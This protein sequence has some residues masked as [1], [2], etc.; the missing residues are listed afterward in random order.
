MNNRRAWL[1]AA[2]AVL[3]GT[4]SAAAA[5]TTTTQPAASAVEEVIVTAQKRAENIQDV[6]LSIMAVSQK[7]MEARG[8][9]DAR[10]LEKVVPNLRLDS[11]AQFAGVSIRIRGFGASSNAAID[12]SV[13]PYIDG[14]FIPRPGAILTTF[15]DVESAEVLRG[16][17]GTLFGRNATV[18]ALSLRTAT[19]RDTFGTKAAIELGSY[20]THKAEGMINAPVNDRL[21][22]RV[23]ALANKT[24]GYAKNLLDGKTYGANETIAGRLSA[25]FQA[26]E[27]VTWIGRV[28]Y[29]RTDGDGYALNQVDVSTLTPTQIAN[30]AARTGTPAAALVYPPT[31]DFAS[32]ITNLNLKDRQYGVSSDL[33]IELGGD[34]TVRMINA[35]RNWRNNQSDGDVVFTPLDLISRDSTFDSKSQSHELQFISPKGALL[36]GKLDFV[37]GLYFF[38]EDYKISEGFNLGSQYCSN[39]IAVAAPA[40]LAACNAGPF[41]GAANGLF[42]QNAK[43]YAAYAQATYAITSTLD[44]ILGA[45]ETKDK[46]HGSFVETVANSAAALLR[47]PENT[48]LKFD[49]S[50]PSWRANLSWHVTPDIMTF[51]TYSTGYKSGGL[52]SA[53]GAAPLGQKRLFNSE[54]SKDWELGMKSVLFDRRLLLNVTAYRTDLDD[55]QERSFDGVSFLIRNA[56]S[57]RAKGVEIEGQ[58]RPIEGVSIDF[59]LAY[60]DSVF[61][62]NKSAPGLPAC[63]GSATSCPTL[64]DLT[65]RRPTY[66]PKWQGNIGA[67]YTTPAFADGYTLSVRGDMAYT[68]SMYTTND[69]SEQGVDDSFT[70]YSGRI[71]LT[72]PDKSWTMA[73]FGDN[74]TNEHYFRGAKFVQTL[75]SIFGV[76]IPATGGTLY[77]GYVGAPRTWGIRV[78]K[79]Y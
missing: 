48:N 61:T 11:I 30:F 49:D 20:G 65:G 58:A 33:S 9:V 72:G 28:D 77:R 59:G 69:L 22:I 36:G 62:S 60:L 51:V 25:K 14:V 74:L 54:K 64:Q 39:V 17:Q 21:A 40:R 18:G 29:A 3:T 10:G 38:E 73:L 13:A 50:Q 79:T 19:P 41:I 15:L 42:Q 76:R 24:D 55:F 46:K 67:E 32:A 1:L 68:G 6:P 31:H 27:N 75:D 16:P 70:L 45:R 57:I 43:S 47:G 23:A 52:N 34:Y 78:T 56:G 71:T 5:Q 66:S 37:A 53:G 8:V 7:A 63:N 44:L 35:Y 2:S 12:P 26:T 4:A